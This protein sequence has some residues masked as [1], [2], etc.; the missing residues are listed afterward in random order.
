MGFLYDI[1][2]R[3]LRTDEG[4]GGG[5]PDPHTHG[6]DDITDLENPLQDKGVI[7]LAADFP[8]PAEVDGAWLY[9]VSADVIDNDGTK[10]N[11]GQ[12][13]FAGEQIFWNGVD[14]TVLGAAAND[15]WPLMVGR[16]SATV[17]NVYLRSPDRVPTNLSGF[18]VP[19]DS[20]I[21]AIGAGT[22]GA[23][24]WVA[25]VR[26]NGVAAVIASLSMAAETKKYTDTLNVDV[27]AG[28]EIQMYCNGTN[29]NRPAMLVLLRR[30]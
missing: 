20:T 29:I 16:N 21:F 27:D 24:T 15:T 10:T 8:T 5:P 25:E 1:L 2:L 4:A 18:I 9:R 28:D 19:V 30:R 12:A 7:A 17:S 6:I 23:E 14:W 26:K 22:N 13:F 3:R 11:T